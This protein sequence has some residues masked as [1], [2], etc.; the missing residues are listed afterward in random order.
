MSFRNEI[1]IITVSLFRCPP[2]VNHHPQEQQRPDYHDDES[3]KTPISC[4]WTFITVYQGYG[5]IEMI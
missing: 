2:H 3:S 5:S 4:D 1:I